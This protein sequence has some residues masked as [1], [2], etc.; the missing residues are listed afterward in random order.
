MEKI[1]ILIIGSGG[2]EHALAWKINQSP[3]CERLFVAPGNAGTAEVAKNVFL[4]LSNH[5]S[6]IDFSKQNSIGLVVVAPDNQLAEGMVDSL[7]RSGIKT[8][9]PTKTAAQLEW[10]KAFAKEFM[11]THDIP[12]AHSQTCT[13]LPEALAY[14]ETQE[15]PIVIKA[16][17]LALGKGVVIAQTQ[18]EAQETLSSFMSGEA[19]GDS[20][21][22]V[23]IEEFLQGKEVSVHAFCDGEN[24]L[25]FP[26]SKDHKRIGE[27]DTGPNTGGMGTIAPVVV[28]AHTLETIHEKIIT[29]VLK[30][31]KKSG[32]PFS[33]VLFPGV[34]LTASGPKV[35]EFNARFGDP[36]TESYV[37]LL[38]SDLVPI[39]LSCID[40]T[41]G[42]QTIVW[43]QKSVATIMIASGGY[44]GKYEKGKIIHG[45]TD[46]QQVV[47][48]VVF[49]A[50]TAGSGSNIITAG[51][52]VL[53][54]SATAG[55][56][57]EALKKAYRAVDSIAFDG[58]QY[59]RDIGASEIS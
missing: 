12:T 14:I 28:D 7:T 5:Q 8:F 34:M 45:L 49:H 55:T 48:T 11:H 35:I 10:S 19:F 52:R 43:S 24:A 38:E 27:N 40:G 26:I 58:M 25:L 51:G 31:M 41:L 36:E 17:G 53:G 44:P 18:E 32:S 6:V 56:L 57:K 23:I 3:L 50:G 54:V 37:R 21:K 59:R 33:G 29:P 42:T 16:D 13:S 47:D 1:N 4:D 15:L 46:A 39:M 9:G 30:G 2:R 22:T 20:G